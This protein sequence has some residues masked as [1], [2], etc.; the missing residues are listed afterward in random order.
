MSL[1]PDGTYRCDR[2]GRE[3]DNGGVQECAIVSTLLDGALVTLH[4][5][6]E[7]QK[8]TPHGCAG[9]ALSPSNL[10]DH[11]KATT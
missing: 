9:H 11:R 3:L 4:L 10:A 1:R 8:G 5:C 2:C 7:P 6:R